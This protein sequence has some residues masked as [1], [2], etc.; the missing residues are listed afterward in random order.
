MTENFAAL[1]GNGITPE[2]GFS[3][4]VI[5]K[6]QDP[7]PRRLRFVEPFAPSDPQSVNLL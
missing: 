1:S 5:R 2:A 3:L 7:P 6:G 4:A